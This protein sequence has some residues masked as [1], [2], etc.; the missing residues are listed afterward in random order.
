MDFKA[1]SDNAV[2]VE[3]AGRLQRERLNQ[4]LSQRELAERAGISLR[5]LK[6]LEGG[7]G[8]SMPTMIRVLRALDRLDRLSA[9]LAEAGP[10]PIQLARMKGRERRRASAR[11]GK[12]KADR[13]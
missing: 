9:F 10:S 4:N 8:V 2:Q 5:T 7:R 1:M 12:R 11:R 3:L 6:Y 13:S